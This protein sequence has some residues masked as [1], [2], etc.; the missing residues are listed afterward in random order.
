MPEHQKLVIMAGLMLVPGGL[1][2]QEMGKADPTMME[3]D[4]SVH[5]MPMEMSAA[6]KFEAEG[7]EYRDAFNSE[8]A[9]QSYLNANKEDSA[10]VT[11]VWKI[12][13]EYTDLGVFAESKDETKAFYADAEKWARDCVSMFPDNADCHLFLAVAV[14]RVALFSGGKKKVN[15]SKEVKEEAIKAIE[16]N[17][18]IDGSYH[19][20]A[21]WNRE[22]A[23]LS[24][25]LRAAAKIIYGGLPPASNE[26]AV[27]NFEKAIDLRPDRMLHY[28]E[29]GITYKDLG[30]KA[31]ARE[32]FEKCLLMDVIERQDTRRQE[33]LKKF[34][35][36]L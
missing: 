2:A 27:M 28:F 34:L 21:R 7:D 33:D 30:N 18:N 10:N 4:S 17:P 25:F 16:L 13:R 15:L 19:V 35:K 26:D 36:K 3:S 22:V 20:L 5:E 23:N 8:M 1:N 32:A 14:G 31:K 6:E 9:L 29:L 24:W 12:V 11:Y